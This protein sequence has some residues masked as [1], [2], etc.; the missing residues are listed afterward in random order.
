MYFYYYYYYYYNTFNI[1]NKILLS[2]F[3]CVQI[4]LWIAMGGRIDGGSGGS[5][6]GFSF[7]NYNKTI[8]I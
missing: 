7:T 5:D 3:V 4:I 8:T 6:G 2:E 1:T